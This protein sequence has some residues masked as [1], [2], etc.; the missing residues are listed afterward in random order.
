M[1]YLYCAGRNIRLGYGNSACVGIEWVHVHEDAPSRW[2]DFKFIR[3]IHRLLPAPLPSIQRTHK[4]K[5]IRPL[6]HINLNSTTEVQHTGDM[7]EWTTAT[8]RVAKRGPHWNGESCFSNIL[9][10]FLTTNFSKIP[11]NRYYSRQ[12]T[13]A[14][15]WFTKNNDSPITWTQSHH[16]YW[17]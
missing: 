13:A 9:Y 10:K 7:A 5:P 2:T 16:W 12:I 15:I 3:K 6:L 4:H 1:Q 17:E 11:L 8:D 14:H